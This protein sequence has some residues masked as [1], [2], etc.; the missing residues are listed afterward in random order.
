MKSLTKF[1][2]I[3]AALAS[4]GAGAALADD[5]QLTN[6][7][8]LEQAQNA[9]RTE[10][11]TTVGVYTN[12]RGVGRNDVYASEQAPEARF[13]LRTNPHGQVFGLWVQER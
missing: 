7:L 2:L 3:V 10:R 4:I 9:S 11:N 8:A 6:R 5:P 13:E 12:D 1:S